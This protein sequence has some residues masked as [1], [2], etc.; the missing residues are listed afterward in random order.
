MRI[1]RRLRAE[2]GATELGNTQFAVLG[3]LERC[4][5]TTAGALAAS[6]QVQPPS[7]TRIIG[8]LEAA[9]LVTRSPDPVDR[10]QVRV[11][12][13]EAGEQAVRDT[14]AL[15]EAWLA[16]RL[17]QLSDPERETLA[18]AA[19]ILARLAER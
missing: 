4:G 14:R 10:R 8:A 16:R 17:M 3:V 13:T 19:G 12:I 2:R 1:A 7:M 18:S 11:G 5:P 9:G 6:E 15:R